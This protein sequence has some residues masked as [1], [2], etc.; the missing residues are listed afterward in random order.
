VDRLRVGDVTGILDWYTRW[1]A[2]RPRP[3]WPSRRALARVQTPVMSASARAASHAPVA[4]ARRAHAP[5][6]TL[7]SGAVQPQLAPQHRALSGR[8]R[9]PAVGLGRL[10]GMR[11][12]LEDLASERFSRRARRARPDHQ[13]R[14]CHVPSALPARISGRGCRRRR[15]RAVEHAPRHAVLVAARHALGRRLSYFIYARIPKDVHDRRRRALDQKTLAKNRTALT[16]PMF[17]LYLNL[18]SAG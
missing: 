16:P 18:D 5:R 14:L 13:R 12:F 1:S 3:R 15:R 6:T 7:A 2:S 10:L 9:L 11:A 17:R 4:R 8:R